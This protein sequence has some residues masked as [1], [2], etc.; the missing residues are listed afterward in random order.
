MAGRPCQWLLKF[1][2]WIKPR[3]P[4]SLGAE[5]VLG[6]FNAK[7]D[8]IEKKNKE[9]IERKVVSNG[10]FIINLWDKGDKGNVGRLGQKM[11]ILMEQG[12]KWQLWSCRRLHSFSQITETLYSARVYQI[13]TVC[14]DTKP[15][16]TTGQVCGLEQFSNL[17]LP[18]L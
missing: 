14:Q 5:P 9:I 10:V 15:A 8:I 16:S 13:P 4:P 17:Y 2:Y 3:L 1:S 18:Y 11:E 6:I 7:L 12:E